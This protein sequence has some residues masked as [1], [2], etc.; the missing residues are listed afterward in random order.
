MILAR[1]RH[2]LIVSGV[3]VDVGDDLGD[4]RKISVNH[5]KQWERKH[6]KIKE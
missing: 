2:L 4:G 3:V 1:S 6:G 5:L